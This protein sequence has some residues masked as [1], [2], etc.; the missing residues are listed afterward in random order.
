[1]RK[2]TRVMLVVSLV[3]FF[4]GLSLS[5]MAEQP[6]NQQ[7]AKKPVQKVAPMQPKLPGK[8]PGGLQQ[9]NRNTLQQTNR[10]GLQQS[11]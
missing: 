5:A 9:T 10:N 11:Y 1:M 2:S 7:P 4:A 3:S 8:P 6:A